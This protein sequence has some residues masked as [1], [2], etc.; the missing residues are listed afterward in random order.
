M[1][2]KWWHVNH[3]IQVGW[4]KW[5]NVSCVTCDQSREASQATK[6]KFY[7]TAIRWVMLH[8]N[9]FWPVIWQQA[10]KQTVAEMRIL[11]WISGYTR[12]DRVKNEC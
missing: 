8:G 4:M 10:H 6:G 9:E 11:G 3:T 7:H 1:M 12:N 5:R 2:G